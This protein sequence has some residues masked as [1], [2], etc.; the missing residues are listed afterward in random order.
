[1]NDIICPNCKIAFKVDEAG[2]ADILKQVRDHQ[3]D[4]ELRKR[5]NIAE[6][7][8]ENAVKL[9]EAKITNTLQKDLARKET[10]LAEIKA[11]KDREFAELTAKKESELAEMKSKI[12]NV[13][14]EKKLAITEAVNKIEKERDEL[15]GELK[16]KDTEKRL[17]ETALNEKYAT[18][19]KTRDDIIKMKD[20]EIALR[21]D[22]K[23]RLSTK[24]V[25][26]T[27]EQHCETEFN[28]LRA[29][30]FKNAYF[31]KD[32]DAKS[33][34]KGDYIYRETDEAGNEIISI[35]FEM[36]NEG[37]ET[38]T[39]KKNEDFLRELDKDRA[40]KK[41]EY[42]VL[43]TLLEAENELY[44]TGIVDAFHKYPK[45]YVVRPQFFIP[46]ITLLRNASMNSLKY[47]TELALV[48]NQNIDITNF[49]ESVNKFKA[50]FSKTY[51]LASRRFKTAIEEIDKTIDHLQKTK[52]ALLS[53][54]NNLRIANNKTE[55]LTI[56]RLTRGNP[57]M[58][59]K[60]AE[61][62]DADKTI[63]KKWH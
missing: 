49:E 52:D 54:E 51:D 34:S 60:F 40:E 46:I 19:L 33:G 25:G 15:A 58:T 53:S 22:M 55:D 28:K 45:M 36:K 44:N 23:V 12:N 48:R 27:L 32:N 29:T 4:E 14:L 39:K 10:E 24:M 62:T 1:M 63:E 20:E 59:A 30:G 3:F 18:E 7:D 16:S 17:L 47:K 2:F 5:L 26:E 61:L 50:G 42:A 31:E 8:K 35:M 6:K 57:T 41:C 37:D 56:K 43:V 38:A 21:K 11:K 13:E 9:A